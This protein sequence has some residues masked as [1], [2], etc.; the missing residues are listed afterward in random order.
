MILSVCSDHIS[1][2]HQCL[3][4]ELL[5]HLIFIRHDANALSTELPQLPNV[6]V[7]CQIECLLLIGAITMLE[8]AELRG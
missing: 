3:T 2:V 4:S 7:Y 8:T 6:C 5:E 1:K